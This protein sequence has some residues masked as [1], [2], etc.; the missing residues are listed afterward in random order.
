MLGD[1][2]GHDPAKV[3]EVGLYVD[4]QTMEAHPFLKP[5]TEGRDFIF[6][7]RPIGQEGF[8]G[9]GNP[10]AYASVSNLAMHVEFGESCNDPLFHIAHETTHI[11]PTFAHIEHHVG[12]ALTRTVVGILPAAF[13]LVDREPIRFEQVRRF[14]RRARR[15]ERRMFDQPNRFFGF[16]CVNGF[17]TSLHK[18]NGFVIVGQSS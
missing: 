14:R 11:A 16:T 3:A 5:N 8:I 6:A 15:I 17:G 12:H 4:R 18:G 7:Y 9:A 10:N 13:A 1:P 2:A